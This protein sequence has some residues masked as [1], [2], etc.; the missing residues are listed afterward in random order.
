[1]SP[2][3]VPVSPAAPALSAEPA[4]VDPER[5]SARSVF[6]PLVVAEALPD[7]AFPVFAAFVSRPAVAFVVRFMSLEV[8]DAELPAAEL[9]D[10]VDAPPLFML[11][12]LSPMRPPAPQA[13]CIEDA[14]HPDATR[15]PDM[16][17]PDVEFI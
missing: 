6:A 5:L 16:A 7:P 10:A 13:L 14:L 12:A 8:P 3:C 15:M 4:V 17:L 2:D 1:M 9:P 11:P